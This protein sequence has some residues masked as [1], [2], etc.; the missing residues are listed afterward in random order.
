MRTSLDDR[1]SE[2]DMS[3]QDPKA[4]PEAAFP[5]ES[6]AGGLR[7]VVAA[8]RGRRGMWVVAMML[9]VLAGIFAAVIGARAVA[10]SDADKAQLASRVASGG[11]AS[12][13]KLALQHEED[14]IVSANAFVVGNPNASPAG[15]DRWAESVHA[16][17]RYPELQNFG[18]LI[19]VPASRLAAVRARINASPVLALGPQTRGPKEPLQIL[20]AGR[21]PFYCLAAAGM[22]RNAATV[23]PPGLDFCALAPTLSKARDSGLA[24]Y[25]P[26]VNGNTTT[27]GVETPVYRGGVTPSSVTGR[28]RAFLGWVGELLTPN[29]V[30]ERALE[31]H[32]NVAVVFRYDSRDAHIAFSRGRAPAGAQSTK[33]ALRTGREAGLNNTYEGWTVQS[34]TA[35]AA[36]GVFENRNALILLIGGILLSAVVGLL[37]LVLGLGR[38]RALSLVHEKTRELFQKNR[39]LSHQALHDA[40][41]GLPNRTLVLDRAEQLLARTAR[42][43]TMKAGALFIDID[44]FKHV[45]DNFGH[46]AGDQLL[47]TVAERLQSTVRDQ[48]TA[49]RLGGDEFVVLVESTDDE[50]TPDLLAERLTDVLREPLV[51][52]DG[53]RI[54][55]VTASIGVAVGQ[56]NTPDD[57][58]RDAD[59]ALYA[60]KAAGK[61]RYALF[62]ATMYA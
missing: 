19:L 55:S 43:P 22:A 29:V 51:L 44:G 30:V 13:L 8:A 37:M 45:N 52:D 58:L 25:A 15:F 5:S 36:S 56:Y 2:S 61:N 28:R 41:T 16:M 27:L 9:L 39:E 14:L 24:S 40:L 35:A 54:S 6:R 31:G 60:A 20:P 21:R 34:F 57:L 4:S 1:V 48:D 3:S 46:A 26:F 53:R 42:Q 47:K 32:P 62:N 59:L 7:G 38:K 50:T 12:T 23:L 17:Q 10:R 18:F 49:G 33:L 11:I